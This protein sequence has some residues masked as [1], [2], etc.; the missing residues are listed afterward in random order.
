MN[1]ENSRIGS[2]QRL[3]NNSVEMESNSSMIY[4]TSEDKGMPDWG[5][6]AASVVLMIIGVFGFVLNLFAIYIMLN[7]RKV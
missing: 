4:N 1:A 7:N 3:M 2:S 5:Y 6:N